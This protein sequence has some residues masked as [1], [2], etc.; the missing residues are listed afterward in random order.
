LKRLSHPSTLALE[1]L[2]RQ[3]GLH[4]S[5]ILPFSKRQAPPSS[6]LRHDDSFRLTI[7]T[8]D[9][10]FYLHL[11]PNHHL[12][13]PAA[14]IN[15]YSTDSNGQSYLTHSE[16]LIRETVKAYWGEVIASDHSSTRM[17]EDAAGAVHQPH[18]SELGWVRLMIHHQGD[19]GNGIAPKFEGAFSVKGVV[20]HIMTKENYLRTKNEFDPDVSQP[21]DDIDS[22]LVIWR[23][24]DVM[25]AQEERRVKRGE[26]IP[27][28]SVPTTQSC[29]H[30]RLKF[31]TDPEQNAVLQKP[32]TV[33]P[34]YS[35]P[36]ELFNNDTRH[37]RDDV[38]GEMGTKYKLFD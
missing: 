8:F 31:N 37:R 38:T 7:S 36:L 14:R 17:R 30:D 24:S 29:G 5:P 1:I 25:T 20:Y 10:T 23:E 2:P 6:T 3:E 33:D 28:V 34:W 21:L 19:M 13:H 35:R 18:P 32:V 4:S 12:V 27:D 15:Y 22:A 16:P 9:E 11:R 26:S